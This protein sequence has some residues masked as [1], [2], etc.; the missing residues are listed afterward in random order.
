MKLLKPMAIGRYLVLQCAALISGYLAEDWAASGSF[1]ATLAVLE[2]HRPTDEE[3]TAPREA[4]KLFPEA[5]RVCKVS[6]TGWARN[7]VWLPPSHF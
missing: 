3:Q 5:S 1:N 7:R 2:K 4:V 6:Q